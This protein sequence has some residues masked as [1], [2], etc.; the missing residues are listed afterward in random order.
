MTEYTLA[1][2]EDQDEFTEG[3][4]GTLTDISGTLSVD[5]DDVI[6][7]VSLTREVESRTGTSTLQSQLALSEIGSTTV[8]EP[9]WTSEAEDADSS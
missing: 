4:Q 1:G 6:R 7:Q 9:E 5:D 2:L 3:I 8:E